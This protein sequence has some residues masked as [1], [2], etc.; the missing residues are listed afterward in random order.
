MKEKEKAKKW[1][2]RGRTTEKVNQIW[3]KIRSRREKILNIGFEM[4]RDSRK[5]DN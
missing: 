3:Q 4:R 2:D 5:K 1:S